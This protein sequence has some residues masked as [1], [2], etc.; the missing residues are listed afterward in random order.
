MLVHLTF[1]TSC[2]SSHCICG[3]QMRWWRWHEW[4][5]CLYF[6][7]LYIFAIRS[8]FYINEYVC[9]ISLLFRSLVCDMFSSKSLLSKKKKKNK[10]ERKIWFFYYFVLLHCLL[11]SIHKVFLRYTV[12]NLGWNAFIV[13]AF[14]LWI[15]AIAIA[16]PL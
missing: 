5:K 11:K 4:Y 14:C 1:L 10:N 9:C 8:D 2:I 16:S 7:S 13:D 3:M 6:H 15:I 12:R